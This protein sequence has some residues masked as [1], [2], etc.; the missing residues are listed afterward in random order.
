MDRRTV[1]TGPRGDAAHGALA[2]QDQPV[3]VVVTVFQPKTD[4]EPGNTI[5]FGG[6]LPG[7]KGLVVSMTTDVLEIVMLRETAD[8]APQLAAAA[9]GLADRLRLRF[10]KAV[11]RIGDCLVEDDP[12]RSDT[13]LAD[14]GEAG[15]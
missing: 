8:L 5:D 4:P 2:W 9:Q 13:A 3:F 6:D 15:A 1:G 11:V 7:L 12:A 10:G 14:K